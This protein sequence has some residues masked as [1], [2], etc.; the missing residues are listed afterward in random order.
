[1]LITAI[2]QRFNDKN[3]KWA[4]IGAEDLDGTAFEFPLFSRSFEV[5][6]HKLAVGMPVALRAQIRRYD[7]KTR[8]NVEEVFSLEEARLSRVRVVHLSTTLRDLSDS[9]ID[10]LHTIMETHRGQ[11]KV[12]LHLEQ[13]EA[14]E[15]VFSFPDQ[16]RLAITD[17]VQ[18]QL[19]K[20][21]FDIRCT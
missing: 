9:T 12:I 20:L 1:M 6:Q 21:R 2:T 13:N 4:I 10:S 17:K 15:A 18:Q 8:I 5:H 16:Q 11:A 7:D 3:E 14:Y 19:R